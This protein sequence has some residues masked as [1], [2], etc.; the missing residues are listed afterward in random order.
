MSEEN[1][2]HDKPHDPS[3]KK[4]LDARKKGDFGKSS[5]LNTSMSYAGVLVV[6]FG[7]GTSSLITLSGGLLSFIAR[8]DQLSSFIFDYPISSVWSSLGFVVIANILPWFI[9]PSL[10]VLFSLCVQRSFVLAPDKLR[11]KINR[12]SLVAN[13]KNKFGTRGLFEFFKSFVKLAIFSV[14]LAIFLFLESDRM[15]SAAALSS[16]QVVDIWMELCL[17]ILCFVL[18]TSLVISLVD[19]V[20][21]KYSHFQKNRMSDKELK[22]EVKESEGDPYFKSARRA[23]AQEISMNQMLQGVKSAD[24]VV[25][26][27]THFAVA[28][29]W[30]KGIDRAPACVAKGRD[31]MAFK[32]RE[33]A[34]MA[35]V[36][37]FRDPPTARGLYADISID[38][39]IAPKYYRAV[40]AAIRFS[41]AMRDKQRSRFVL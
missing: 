2:S 9:F 31:E 37:I 28:L 5:D 19:V 3:Q 1:E 39:E 14:L 22:D 15:I 17:V 30:A 40:A 16:A 24:V 20:W 8:P 4:L 10:G 25:V 27:P 21:Q 6:A 11:F 36:P 7:F 29:K 35:S 38:Q 12:I 32:I 41:E 18:V 23:K 34:D 26:N 13:W 33:V